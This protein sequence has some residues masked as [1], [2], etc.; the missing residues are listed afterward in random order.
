MGFAIGLPLMI[1]MVYHIFKLIQLGITKQIDYK[2][3]N[4]TNEKINYQQES[5]SE[6]KLVSNYTNDN[7][8]KLSEY[9]YFSSL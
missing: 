2:K 9:F 5:S 8:T 1:L 7:D 4:V 3:I 6:K